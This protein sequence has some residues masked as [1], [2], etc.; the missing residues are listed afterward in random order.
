MTSGSRHPR[1]ITQRRNPSVRFH[2]VVPAL[3]LTVFTGLAAGGYGWYQTAREIER[4][5]VFGRSLSQDEVCAYTARQGRDLLR[6]RNSYSRLAVAL[7]GVVDSGFKDETFLAG[8]DY[9]ETGAEVIGGD[10]QTLSACSSFNDA[11]AIKD[12]PVGGPYQPVAVEK[13][14]GRLD[15]KDRARLLRVLNRR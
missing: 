3:L 1:R 10:L 4:A 12:G 14:A 7:K 15:E 13:P 8:Q 5:R 9:A 2:K 6:L 11:G